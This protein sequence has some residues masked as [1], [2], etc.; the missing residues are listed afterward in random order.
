MQSGVWY[1][2][3]WVLVSCITDSK[4]PLEEVEPDRRRV[5][6]GIWSN[7]VDKCKIKPGA[8]IYSYRAAYAYSHHGTFLPLSK[9]DILHVEHNFQALV[10]AGTCTIAKSDSSNMVLHRAMYLLLNG[11]GKVRAGTCTIAKSDS[12]NMVLHR[13]MYLLLNGFGNL[14]INIE[15][16]TSG[17]VSS[18]GAAVASSSFAAV[19]KFLMP[20]LG[21]VAVAV[22]AG[23]GM[24]HLGRYSSEIGVRP[25]VIKVEVEVL[26]PIKKKFRRTL[27]SS[28]C[29]QR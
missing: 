24:Y 29:N 13:A 9:F 20:G 5:Q 15:A 14:L 22:A 28:R 23:T 17:Q 16:G 10:R 8:H 25:D 19:S 12:S 1:G 4:W 3:C 2:D 27:G 18:V 21:A 11:F 26:L 7:R 6:M